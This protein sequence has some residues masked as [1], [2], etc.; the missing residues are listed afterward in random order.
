YLDQAQLSANR[1]RDLIRQMLT[2]SRG[3]RGERKPV[4]I[5]A[6]LKE[7]VKLLRSTLP[8]TVALRTSI[9]EN[10]PAALVDSVQMDQV[11]MNLCI[12]AR[13]AMHG[14]G[15]IRLSVGL[16]ENIDYEC[17]SC[18]KSVRA[19]RM[20]EL[21]VQ[22]SGNGIPPEV[23]ERMFDPFFTTKEVGQ[24][25]GMG[26]A[27][28]HGIVHEHNG[29]IVLE[30][31]VGRGTT[32]R[33]MLPPISQPVAETPSPTSRQAARVTR[34]QLSG[35]VLLVDDEPLVRQFMSELL[36]GWGLE[37]SAH[38]SAATAR[39]DIERD[40][41]HYD[42][43][44]TDHTMPGMTGLDLACHLYALRPGLPIVLYTGYGDNLQSTDLERCG[45][46][47]VLPKPI[48]PGALRALLTRVLAPSKTTATDAA[49]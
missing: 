21:T 15:T 20:I 1:A 10:V 42:A 4:A 44:I 34:E 36:E 26:L 24:G 48:E 23:R 27:T 32:F 45:V 47:A 33:V 6:L 25:S 19:A 11:L 39:E 12:N 8:S 49:G 40:L 37:V 9:D 18:R 22:D 5:P 38:E 2:F 28:V 7:S 41:T 13:D 3:Q 35:R 30:T 17:A 29:H 43:V 16:T 46:L 14:A 31:D